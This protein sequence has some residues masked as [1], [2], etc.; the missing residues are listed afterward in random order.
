MELH[1]VLPNLWG[2]GLTKVGIATNSS[3]R[4]ALTHIPGCIYL[5]G[6]FDS[7]NRGGLDVRINLHCHSILSDGVLLPSEI[8]QR[9]AV[10]GFDAL[11]I[12]DHVDASN[13]EVT[14]SSLLELVREQPNDWGIPLLVGVELTHVA[15]QSIAKLARRA[16]TLGAEV[17]VVH[18]ET[19]V[20]P[21]APG[22]NRAAIASPDVDI[23]AHPGFITSEEARLAAERGCLIEITTRHGHS[24][25]NG[26]VA[27]VCREANARMVVN[28][29]AHTPSDFVTLEFAQ[30]VARGAGLTTV[31]AWN[32][33]VTE[34]HV[35]LE[36]VLA[37][38][39]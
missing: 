4:V 10:M 28:S 5:Q 22:T 20:E 6:S 8:M 19:P 12:T 23:L 1:L 2:F 13:I 14:I 17:I 29:D 34:P 21:V 36:K 37:A 7:I 24:L 35:V 16:R 27:H 18:G 38:R 31:E 30:R 3:I 32:A 39:Q 11:A 26:H 33:T 25:T 15:P 9:V